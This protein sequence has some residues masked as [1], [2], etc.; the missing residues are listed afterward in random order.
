[1]RRGQIAHTHVRSSRFLG[2]GRRVLGV[3]RVD[4]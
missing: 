1:M 4:R 2:S 3:T